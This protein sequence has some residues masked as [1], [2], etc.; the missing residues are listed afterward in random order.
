MGLSDRDYMKP[1]YRGR[2]S[3]R[4]PSLAQRLKFA[5]WRLLKKRK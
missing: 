4:R 1:N 3:K 5:L 2:S